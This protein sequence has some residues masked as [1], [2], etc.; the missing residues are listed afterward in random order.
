M[1]R[2]IVFDIGNVLTDYRWREFLQ[3]KG[4]DDAM[5]ERIARAS[6]LNPAWNEIDRGVWS[7]EE[8]LLEFIRADPEIAGEI[9]RAFADIHGLVTPRSY[10]IPWI[11]ELRDK[12]FS[13]YYLS[14][15]SHKAHVECAEALTFIPCT[16]GGILSYQEKMIK[17]D[18]AIYELLINRY[19]LKA[20]ECVFL[21][22]MPK[23]VEAARECGF[24]GIRFETKEQAEAELKALL[25]RN[26]KE[27]KF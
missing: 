2:N 11:R 16:D 4:F 22:D 9:R 13:V 17:P 7:E 5:V 21:D 1:I 23:N 26:E 12:G 8:I 24:F 15:F 10:A 20:E 6:V 25:E 3:D 19:G 14:N 18:P 27:K